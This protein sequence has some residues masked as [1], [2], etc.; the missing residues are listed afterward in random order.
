VG[1]T[2]D[3]TRAKAAAALGVDV[4]DITLV[5]DEDVLDTLFSSGL[6]P[7]SVF[8]WLHQTPDLKAFF[9]TTLLETGSD[10]LFFWVAH[11]VMMSLHLTDLLLLKS[12][13]YALVGY[14]N[15]HTWL[16][17]ILQEILLGKKRILLCGKFSFKYRNL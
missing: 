2:E 4:S 8:G 9:P 13:T 3:E 6:F 16:I 15:N 1:R 17:E 11:M 12:N 7:F 5:Q 10:I 14:N